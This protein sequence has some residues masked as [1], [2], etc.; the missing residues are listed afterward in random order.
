MSL[1]AS[2]QHHQ[3]LSP[4]SV[5]DVVA[6]SGDARYQSFGLQQAQRLRC[7]LPCYAVI[8]CQCRDGRGWLTR[9]QRPVCYL[10]PKL[11]GHA[12]VSARI[13]RRHAS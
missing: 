10:L 12:H 3:A 5:S 8:L 9:P 4:R 7:C 1:Q 13:R 2:E 11:I 6:Q